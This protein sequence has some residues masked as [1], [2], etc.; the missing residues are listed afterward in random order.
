MSALPVVDT[1]LVFDL[2]GYHASCYPLETSDQRF[3]GVTYFEDPGRIDEGY[4]H[5]VRHYTSATFATGK[6]AIE[7]A[8][9]LAY[10]KLARGD[11]AV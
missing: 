8:A 9:T 2:G 3:L 4:A 10:E 5:G 11:I 7:A 1:V 6:A